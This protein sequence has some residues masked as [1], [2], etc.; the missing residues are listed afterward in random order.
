MGLSLPILTIVG[1]LAAALAVAAA[2]GRV[3]PPQKQQP[4]QAAG[5]PAAQVAPRNRSELRTTPGP[6][7]PDDN[8]V[9]G[10]SPPDRAAETRTPQA[11]PAA[12]PNAPPSGQTL[13]EGAILT[14][15]SR[16]SV[17]AKIRYS[18]DLMG[19]RP[20]GSGVYL[21]Q[22][23]EQGLRLRFETRFQLAGEPS[24]LLQ[25]CDGAHLWVYQKL[26]DQES[27]SRI[28]VA[29]VEQALEE[30]G[31]IGRIADVGWWPGLG[32]LTRLLRAIHAAFDFTSVEEA[33]LAD[34]ADPVPVWRLRGEW[35]PDKLAK[36]FPGRK[37]PA[38]PRQP[39]DLAKLDLGQLPRHV[40]DHV[41]LYLGK[42]DRFPYRIEYRRRAPP[43]QEAEGGSAA[44][45]L[46]TMQ[47]F[48]RNLNASIHPANF[49]YSPGDLEC[50]DRTSQFLKELRLAP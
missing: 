15:E 25:V 7:A 6:R 34:K 43:D 1:L 31:D 46:L 37:Q 28:D 20:V 14:L 13:L 42:T 12:A 10:P 47:L 30:S 50:P 11:V 48:E 49:L 41:V 27:L 38:N 5:R 16:R 29:R 22:R 24:S 39:T 19:Q 36:A 44:R 3:E 26:G 4:G 17:S 2:I 23:S 8:L 21:E 9:V 40:P 45:S 32:G 18:V 35:K 33:Q